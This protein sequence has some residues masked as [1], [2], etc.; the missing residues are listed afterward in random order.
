MTDANLLHQAIKMT[1]EPK[2]SLYGI[3]RA[4]LGALDLGTLKQLSDDSP[5]WVNPLFYYMR[6]LDQDRLFAQCA[7]KGIEVYLRVVERKDAENDDQVVRRLIAGKE[8]NEGF[9]AINAHHTA[10]LWDMLDATLSDMFAL[11]F[12]CL[13]EALKIPVLRKVRFGIADFEDLPQRYRMRMVVKEL[14]R[15]LARN[16]PAARKNGVEIYEQ[17]LR[18]FA[19]KET[20]PKSA[21]ERLVELRAV[22]NIIVHNMSIADGHFLEQC[23]WL[24]MS[25]GADVKV[26]DSQYTSYVDAAGTYLLATALRLHQRFPLSPL[27]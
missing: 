27:G 22:R 18:E 13:P 2:F 25:L 7:K 20:A 10:H 14:K 8:I 16:G 21:T 17:I 4:S 26:T 1:D 11:V 3:F 12:M 24:S 15:E 5:N 19:V 9:P 23:P 6:Y